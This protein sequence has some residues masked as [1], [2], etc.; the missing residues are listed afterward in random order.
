MAQWGVAP[1]AA[2][3]PVPECACLTDTS[4]TGYHCSLCADWCSQWVMLA[5]TSMV[6]HVCCSTA[7]PQVTFL[8]VCVCA[9]VRVRFCASIWRRQR[10]NDYYFNRA[11]KTQFKIV[12]FVVLNQREKLR[13]WGEQYVIPP[14]Y[15]LHLP[16]FFVSSL[17]S[18]YPSFSPIIFAI[19]NLCADV[20]MPV[21]LVF[22]Q[23]GQRL[24]P[25]I[26]YTRS[27]RLT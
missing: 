25:P 11:D 22:K 26:T 19:S 4:Y 15:L 21:Y 17:V 1:S 18:C 16:M 3:H 7:C 10:W 20:I 13:G 5:G 24:S 27:A 9:F 2:L 8:C 12:G 14:L 23:H 6:L